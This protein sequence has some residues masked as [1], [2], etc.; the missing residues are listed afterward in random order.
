MGKTLFQ[1]W[2]GSAPTATTETT[3]AQAE[4]GVAE[5]QFILGLR[6]AN[7]VGT[8]QDFSKAAVWYQKAA[9]QNHPLAQFNLGVMYALGQGLPCDATQSLAWTQKAADLGDAGAQFSLGRTHQRASLRGTPEQTSAQ[10]IQAYKWMRLAADQGYQG[11]QSA[12]EMLN[13]RMSR[14]DVAEGGRSVAAF[15]SAQ[16]GAKHSP[17]AVQKAVEKSAVEDVL[18][19][20]QDLG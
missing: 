2:F 18:A 13:L 15:N 19:R 20:N 17:A 4:R 8:P 12:C 6:H 16:A 14:E 11:S 5:A 10:R 9:H 3:E 7:G 1:R